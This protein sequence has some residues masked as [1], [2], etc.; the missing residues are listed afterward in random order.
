MPAVDY[1]VANSIILISSL[2]K[3]LLKPGG[4]H[5]SYSKDNPCVAGRAATAP[6]IRPFPNRPDQ[7]GPFFLLL[8]FWRKSDLLEKIA[9]ANISLAAVSIIVAASFG[10]RDNAVIFKG[11]APNHIAKIAIASILFVLT[12]AIA[13]L[14]WRNPGLFRGRYKALYLLANLVCFAL[15]AVEG[16]LGAIIVYGF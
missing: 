2:P 12:S 6:N 13:I 14:R 3:P 8:A 10:V 11:A 15:V 7:R 16:F 9:F 4:I 5:G 1:D